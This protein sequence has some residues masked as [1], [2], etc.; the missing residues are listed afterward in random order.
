MPMPGL[1]NSPL[2]NCSGSRKVSNEENSPKRGMGEIR[3]LISD[4]EEIPWDD[5]IAIPPFHHFANVQ[6][7]TFYSNGYEKKLII[8][9]QAD[10]RV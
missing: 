10:K 7:A 8:P 4:L 1:L 9:T 3:A 2:I 6:K 5:L